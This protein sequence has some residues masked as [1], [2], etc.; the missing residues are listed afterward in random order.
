[1][2]DETDAPG[3]P[4][5]GTSLWKR[6]PP[7]VLITVATIF[8]G[9]VWW[10]AKMGQTIEAHTVAIEALV[11]RADKVQDHDRRISTLEVRTESLQATENDIAQRLARIEERITFIADALSRKRP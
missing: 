9:A 8:L 5:G 2:A 7:G 6:I 1:M 3:Q 10:T 11:V 4:R